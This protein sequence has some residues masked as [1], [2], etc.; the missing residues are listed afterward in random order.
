MAEL[1]S[2]TQEVMMLFRDMHK[3]LQ[4]GHSSASELE[5]LTLAQLHVLLFLEHK[6]KVSMK[7]I[8]EEMTI[9]PASATA[10]IGKM[11][12][13][14]YLVRLEDP[15]DRRT[16]YITLS[17][18]AKQKIEKMK[19]TKMQHYEKIFESLSTEERKEFLRLMKKIHAVACSLAH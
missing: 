11:V 3:C 13:K 15:Q 19:H 8:A 17:D 12:E 9:T 14:H 5:S 7:Q 4:H 1:L 2:F 18:D 16:V 10:L 6:E